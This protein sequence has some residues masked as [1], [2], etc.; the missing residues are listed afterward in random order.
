MTVRI[1]ELAVS[2]GAITPGQLALAQA[3]ECSRFG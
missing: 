1:G 3:R 2:S